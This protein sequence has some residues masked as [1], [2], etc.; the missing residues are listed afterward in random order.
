M[1]KSRKRQEK[2]ILQWIAKLAIIHI[3]EKGEHMLKVSDVA[4]RLNVTSRLV[5]NLIK[6]GDLEAIKIGKRYRV[7][8]E[9]LDTY[10]SRHKT[11]ASLSN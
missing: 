11:V 2:T 9:D 4:K 10:V 7:S 3:Q 8:Q 1:E 5:T 6:S